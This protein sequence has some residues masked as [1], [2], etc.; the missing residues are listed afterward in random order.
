MVKMPLIKGRSLVIVLIHKLIFAV[1][2]SLATADAENLV[3]KNALEQTAATLP[4]I[5]RAENIKVVE[6]TLPI[7]LKAKVD[8]GA[9]TSSINAQEIKLF[10]KD[11]RKFVRF[12][13]T[14]GGQKRRIIAPLSRKGTVTSSNGIEEPRLFV[15]LPIRVG[16]K[17]YDTEFSLANRK[18]M[19]YPVLLGRK[20]LQNNFVVDVSKINILSAPEN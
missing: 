2:I 20:F 4:T 19:E 17:E 18:Q 16:D 10:V 9:L 1:F 7:S 6:G 15:K 11:K 14:D 8:T 13:I 3:C 12:T 5:G